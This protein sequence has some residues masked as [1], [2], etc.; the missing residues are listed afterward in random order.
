MPALSRLCGD[1]RKHK[2]RRMGLCLSCYGDMR[3]TRCHQCREKA[4]LT[5]RGYCLSCYTI[6]TNGRTKT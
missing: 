5:R 4:K 2:A 6:I 1:C 3:K